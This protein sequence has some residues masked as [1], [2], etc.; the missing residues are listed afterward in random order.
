LVTAAALVVVLYTVRTKETTMPSK[1]WAR[2]IGIALF[3]IVAALALIN[4]IKPELN[5]QPWRDLLGALAAF[6]LLAGNIES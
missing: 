6:I 5:L 1:L 3:A 4:V 2:R